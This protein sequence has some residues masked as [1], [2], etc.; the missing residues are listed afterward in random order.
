MMAKLCVM[1]E[2]GPAALERAS[3]ALEGARVATLFVAPPPGHPLDERTVKPLVDLAQRRNVAAVLVNDA[4]LARRVGAD[5]VHVGP[6]EDVVERFAEVRKLLGADFI[7][8]A[9]AGGSRHSA[10]CLGEAGADY[11]AFSAVPEAADAAADANACL[12]LCAW[13]SDIFEVPVLAMDVE[14]GADAAEYA[15][16]GTD[17]VCARVPA[18][19]AAADIIARLAAIEAALNAGKSHE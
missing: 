15:E 8:G 1:I 11:V 16:A 7:A 10:M 14:S 12:D 6:G 19:L 9:D 18:G 2:A 13:W 3:A 5:G 4:A 17:F